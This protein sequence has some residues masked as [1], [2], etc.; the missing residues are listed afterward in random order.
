MHPR[1]VGHT[2]TAMTASRAVLLGLTLAVGGV[3]WASCDSAGS[4]EYSEDPCDPNYAPM[5]Y[6][7]IGPDGGW[8]SYGVASTR[9]DQILLNV[10][11]GVWS[12]CWE[13]QLEPDWSAPSYPSGFVP[14]SY[15][16][17]GAVAVSIYRQTRDGDRIYAPDSMYLELSFPT[18]YLPSDGQEPL[19]V[20]TYDGMALDWRV[21]LPDVVDSDFLT[22]RT[23]DWRQPWYFGRVDLGR[24]DF[25]RYMEPALE[26]HIGTA[27]W[28]RI[29]AEADSLHNVM[30]PNLAWSCI[31]ANFVEGIFVALRDRGVAG[32]QAIQ[33]GLQCGDCDVMS[34]VF[35]EEWRQYLDV[36]QTGLMIDLLSM[37]VPGGGVVKEI[38]GQAISLVYDWCTSSPF[39]CDYE[40]Y[41]DEI[42]KVWFLYMAEYYVGRGLISL[43][44]EVKTNYLGCA[45]P[46]L[47]DWG[48]SARWSPESDTHMGWGGWDDR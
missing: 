24:I 43:V 3:L 15:V 5:H 12:S 13:V 1:R 6:T 25:A 11:A 7:I 44:Q 18:L 26:D 33:A 20:F 23:G 39:A 14:S 22:A 8:V 21:V 47:G 17:A 10:P 27:T 45:S 34:D 40:C 37:A 41:F 38:A 19:A 28:E 9:G 31:A 29:V 36:K 35:W 42:P 16:Y 48:S 46:A 2:S 32:I 30:A 4:S